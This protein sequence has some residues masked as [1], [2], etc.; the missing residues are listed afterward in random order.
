[1][2]KN[3]PGH[4]GDIGFDSWVMMMPWRRKWQPTPVF[5]SGKPYGHRSLVGYNPWGPKR[6]GHDLVTKIM[7]SKSKDS[8]Q[9]L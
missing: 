8:E 2:V 4:A 5:S 9:G 1:M 3:E 7:G 6:I